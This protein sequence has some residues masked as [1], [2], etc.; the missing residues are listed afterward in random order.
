MHFSGQR[1]T[2]LSAICF[3][4]RAQENNTFK[5]PK[6]VKHELFIVSQSYMLKCM[7]KK[8]N[9]FDNQIYCPEFSM[10]TGAGESQHLCSWTLFSNEFFF[11]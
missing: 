1:S 7:C 8:D 9:V 4:E 3:Q 11:M 6:K 5:C 2:F 10:Q